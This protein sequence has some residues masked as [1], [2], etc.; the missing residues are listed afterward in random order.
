[1]LVTTTRKGFNVLV[2]FPEQG[3]SANKVDYSIWSYE[4][5]LCKSSMRTVSWVRKIM[6]TKAVAPLSTES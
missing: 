2:K 1:M 6:K 4:G 5:E 3:R